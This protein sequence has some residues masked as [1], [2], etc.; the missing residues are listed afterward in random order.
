M[1][2]SSAFELVL[3]A[4]QVNSH[5]HFLSVRENPQLL[6]PVSRFLHDCFSFILF[7]RRICVEM[8]FTN[9]IKSHEV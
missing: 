9:Q 8:L 5:N 1:L 2:P 6:L 7:R 4:R 3:V